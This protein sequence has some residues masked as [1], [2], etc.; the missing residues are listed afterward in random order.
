MVGGSGAVV[1]ELSK[2]LSDDGH[3]VRATTSK[4]VTQKAGGKV[5]RVHVDLLTSEGMTNA[6]EGI[7][8]AFMMAP[9]AY[10]AWN[11]GSS[12][13]C[14]LCIGSLVEAGKNEEY[15]INI[16]KKRLSEIAANKRE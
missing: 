6:F 7:D 13:V 9:A 8:R 2:Q 5:E 10:P 1:S 15:T 14:G 11:S 12:L 3:S 4:K 16:S